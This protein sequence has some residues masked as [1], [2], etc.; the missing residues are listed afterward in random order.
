MGPTSIVQLS[1]MLQ[2]EW[3]RIPVDILHK[4]V[5]SMTDRMAAVIATRGSKMNNA[6]LYSN[7]NSLQTAMARKVLSE[8][9]DKLS[10]QP[11]DRIL[12]VGCGNGNITVEELLPRV[13]GDFEVLAGMDISHTM[14]EFASS[15]YK[16]PK[17]KFIQADLAAEIPAESELRTPGFD[18]IFSSYCLNWIP[19]QRQAVRNIYNMLRPGGE[20]VLLISS[21]TPAYSAYEVQSKKSEWKQYLKDAYKFITPL[22]K[23]K[24]AA[25]DFYKIL[26]DAGFEIINCYTEKVQHDYNTARCFKDSVKAYNPFI[27]KIPEDQQED[28]MLDLLLEMTKI[29]HVETGNIDEKVTILRQEILVAYVKKYKKSH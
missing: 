24:D 11:G 27:D 17:I 15:K 10:W 13:P 8:Y 21:W 6:I 12:D 23:S 22:Q 14:L 20:A 9:M 5:E 25:G 7:H 28:Y 4:L 1:A 29:K 3:R 18:K 16:H 2:E 19:D 26:Q